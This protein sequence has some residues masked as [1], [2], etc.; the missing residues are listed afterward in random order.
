MTILDTIIAEKRKFVEECK[1]NISPDSLEN[2][3]L[4]RRNTISLKNRLLQPGSSG[5]IAEFK[6]QSPSKGI[7]NNKVEPEIITRAYQEAGVA[8]VSILTDQPFFGGNPE[9]IIKSRNNLFVPILRKD[10]IV[11]EYQIIEA[12]AMGADLILL[13]A[14]VLNK[15]E[16]RNFAHLARS[17]GMETLF[18]VHDQVELDKLCPEVTLVGVNNRNL[19]TFEVNIQQSIELAKNIPGEF[20]KVSESG[21]E[22]VETIRMLREEGFHAFLIGENFMKTANPG[23]A[24]HNFI[25]EL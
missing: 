22:Q 13:I 1:K 12:R 3:S 6:R 19:K 15:E 14:A 23:L 24:C 11:D 8:A 9:D 25:R 17:L 18:E 10:F 16:I 5:I 20:L 2:T 21:I 7:I 4:F